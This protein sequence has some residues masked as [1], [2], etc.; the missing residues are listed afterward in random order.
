MYGDLIPDIVNKEKLREAAEEEVCPMCG[1]VDVEASYG[2]FISK[3]KY[4]QSMVCKAC[5]AQ[6]DIIY[7][8]DLNII[9]VSTG[10]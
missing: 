4:M 3:T 7:D 1:S 6:W 5:N 10:G 9:D 2:V 8:N